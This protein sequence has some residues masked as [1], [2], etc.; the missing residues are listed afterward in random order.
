MT[1]R[2]NYLNQETAEEAAYAI[3][4]MA[5]SNDPDERKR[6]AERLFHDL[7]I[8]DNARQLGQEICTHV[9]AQRAKKATR[10]RPMFSVEDIVTTDDD[11]RL[12]VDHDRLAV[13]HGDTVSAVLATLRS[14]V[15]TLLAESRAV[16]SC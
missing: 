4:L 14:H 1:Q 16:Q 2:K 11:G 6:L 5:A 8:S 3:A 10:R 7:P 13:A 12:R 9:L 15:A